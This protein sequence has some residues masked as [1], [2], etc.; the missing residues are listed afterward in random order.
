MRREAECAIRRRSIGEARTSK[1]KGCGK[2]GKGKEQKKGRREK[3]KKRDDATLF[4]LLSFHP[5]I[6]RIVSRHLQV[7]ATTHRNRKWNPN[8]GM[9]KRRQRMRSTHTHTRTP[10]HVGHTPLSFFPTGYVA[11]SFGV[12][13]RPIPSIQHSLLNGP[14]TGQRKDKKRNKVTTKWEGR[15]DGR[16]EKN[17]RAQFACFLHLL[18]CTLWS[19]SASLSHS[20]FSSV[21]PS[22]AG[23]NDTTPKYGHA[24]GSI[25]SAHRIQSLTASHVRSTI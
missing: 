19:W 10:T 22:F 23:G 25:C 8:N 14:W 2:D 18:H 12:C 3:N 16:S 5:F 13:M 15:R 17:A 9:E 4:I 20:S 7:N 11:G 24:S 6:I 1:S 21:P